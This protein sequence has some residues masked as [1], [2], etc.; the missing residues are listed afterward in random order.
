MRAHRTSPTPAPA[1]SRPVH[2]LIRTRWC[3][4]VCLVCGE[5]NPRHGLRGRQTCPQC[6][7]TV[8]VFA[9]YRDLRAES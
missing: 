2:G 7:A 8:R 6:G 5:E 1:D 9:L 4:A 3:L